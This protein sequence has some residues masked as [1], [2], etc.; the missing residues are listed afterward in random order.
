[1][2]TSTN[3]PLQAS[4]GISPYDLPDG[5]SHIGT[6]APV[7]GNPFH[8]AG[9]TRI[10]AS[11]LSLALHR[12]G[13]PGGNLPSTQDQQRLTIIEWRTQLQLAAA[14]AGFAL[15]ADIQQAGRGEIA[16]SLRVR[17]CPDIW[18]T[19]PG[20]KKPGALRPPGTA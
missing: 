3:A 18:H 16:P 4:D 19:R 10:R 2:V 13:G 17:A 5:P 12:R 9:R 14:R 8:R 11:S 6:S 20:M 1:M 15:P 7:W